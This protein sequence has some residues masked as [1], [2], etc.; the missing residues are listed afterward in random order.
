MQHGQSEERQSTAHGR[1]DFDFWVGTWRG[2][3][4]KRVN[5]LVLG[6]DEWIAFEGW[7]E[8]RPI[9]GGLGSTDEFSAPD[10]PGRPGFAG[11]SLRLFEPETELWRIW[12]A[13]TLSTGEIDPPVIGRF[14]DGIGRF[15]CDEVIE[16]T[17]RQGALRVEG[18]RARLGPLGAVVLVRPRCDLG[19]ELDRA[20]HAGRRPDRLTRTIVQL[21]DR[22]TRAHVRA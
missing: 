16:D 13:S 11:F 9:L 14:H 2:A 17:A 6:D 20:A 12:W 18:H 8:A 10:F 19:H 1:H 21:R 3:N 5:P 15:E 22:C 4:R 7:C